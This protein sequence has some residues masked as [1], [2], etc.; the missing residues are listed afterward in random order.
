M[1]K[2]GL[3]RLQPYEEQCG[4]DTETFSPVIKSST[5]HV[6]LSL[7]VQFDWSFRQLDVFNAFLHEALVEEVFMRQP[8]GFVDKDHPHF[9][10][11]LNKSSLWLETWLGSRDYHLSCWNLALLPHLWTHHYLYSSLVPF[12]SLC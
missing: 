8:K 9:V 5:I 3:A 12:I 1:P 10:C 7:A 6:I 4:I 11:K 2:L